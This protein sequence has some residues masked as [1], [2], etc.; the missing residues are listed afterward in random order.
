M[1]FNRDNVH[2]PSV[3]ALFRTVEITMLFFYPGVDGDRRN[4]LTIIPGAEG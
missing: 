1:L 3:R 2:K 4:K